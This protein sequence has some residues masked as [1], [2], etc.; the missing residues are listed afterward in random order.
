MEPSVEAFMGVLS[1]LFR[2]NSNGAM[3]IDRPARTFQK[4]SDVVTD[5]RLSLEEKKKALNTW[6]QDARQLMTAS[7]EGMPGC[8]EGLDPDDHH[9]M[10]EVV[11]AKEALGEKP[12]HKPAQ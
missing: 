5:P 12:K 4:P 8:R 7:N 11:R 9:L 3:Q 1:W 10:G 6:E 2:G